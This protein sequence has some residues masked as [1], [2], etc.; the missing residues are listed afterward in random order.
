MKRWLVFSITG[1]ILI[2]AGVSITGEAIIFKSAGSPWFWLGTAGLV[3]LNTG[4]S[5]VGQGVIYRVR[6]LAA[7]DGR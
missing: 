1:L 4:V 6:L 5:F 7:R 3:V 2:G